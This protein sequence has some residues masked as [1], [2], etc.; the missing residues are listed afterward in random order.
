M[1]LGELEVL[2]ALLGIL[3]PQEGLAVL[4]AAAP[5][6][7]RVIL[8]V[9]LEVTRHRQT[10]ISVNVLALLLK[11]GQLEVAVGLGRLTAVVLDQTILALK[12]VLEEI[13]EGALEEMVR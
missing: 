1:G 9:A 3:A 13:L 11:T 7:L 10:H 6:D 8:G 5:E 2:E 4:L 12:E